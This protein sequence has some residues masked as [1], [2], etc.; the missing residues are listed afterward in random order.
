M[1]R[2]GGNELAPRTARVPQ[3]LPLPSLDLAPALSG[4]HL[5]FIPVLS[6]LLLFIVL[7]KTNTD[8]LVSDIRDENINNS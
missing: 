1:P 4:P 3:R 6:E 5:G 2:A 7:W 8:F